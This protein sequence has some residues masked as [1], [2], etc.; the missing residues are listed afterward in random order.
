M[1][2]IIFITVT[3]IIGIVS[4]LYYAGLP[5]IR[6]FSND[7]AWQ[8]W[9]NNLSNDDKKSVQSYLNE[10]EQDRKALRPI[11][12]YTAEPFD[13]ISAL[14]YRVETLKQGTG[15]VIT[16]DKNYEVVTEYFGWRSDG[17]IFVS[18]QY[19][20]GIN[21]Y[22]GEVM[23][24]SFNFPCGT[25]SSL[26]KGLIGARVG[27]IIR[28]TVPDGI[29]NKPEN[30]IKANGDWIGAEAPRGPQKYIVY[31][32]DIKRIPSDAMRLSCDM[33]IAY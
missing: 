10:V 22:Q 13:K 8:L 25:N 4:V 12:G 9:W 31:I 30:I 19:E 15:S 3:F 26:E 17:R 24:G 21:E 33:E 1:I 28:I 27:S 7:I 23:G 14:N 18:T 16:G 2:L 5:I 6:Q 32:K 20:A 11:A 29:E